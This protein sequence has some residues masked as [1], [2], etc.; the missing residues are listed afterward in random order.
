MRP[1][2]LHNSL[3][4]ERQR[5]LPHPRASA[6][7]MY[8]CGPTVYDTSHI[9]NLRSYVF[10]DIL[11]RTLEYN[12]L[13][14]R[15]VI[16]ITDFG[17]LS[18]D[19]DNGKDKMSMALKREG[20]PLSLEN[21]RSLAEKY[22]QEFMRD[23][24]ALNIDVSR[25]QFPRASDYVPA[26]IAMIHALEEKGYTYVATDGVYFDSTRFPAYGALGNIDL[27]GLKKGAR[28]TASEEKKN[29][30]DFLLWKSDK[31]M[32]WDS[33]WGMGF[34]G[35]H[36]ECS[37]MIRKTLG[38]Q[39]DIHT[40]GIDLMPTHHNNEI[41]QSEASSGKKPFSRFWLHHEFL[42]LEKEKISKSVGNVINLPALTEKGSIPSLIDISYLALT[43]AL[44][45][46]SPGR[47]L[48]LHRPRTQ[49]FEKHM[50]NHPMAAV[51]RVLISIASTRESMTTSILLAHSVWCG[52][53]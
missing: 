28:V 23:L 21:M 6:V 25:I 15:Q 17:H 49:G 27:K 13:A 53:W 20:L 41:A 44:R 51:L 31:K 30:S 34:P 5:F 50:M 19:A 40:G 42:N 11:R 45:S 8:N 38:E 43:I 46:I 26:Q 52:K 18:S 24:T 14:V 7:R 4:N 22:S 10:A 48:R 3:G 35:W 12:G 2:Y 36:I 32:G 37:A 47:R 33:P 39:I 16:N 29:P 9:G 1:L